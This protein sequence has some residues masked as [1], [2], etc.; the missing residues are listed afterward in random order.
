MRPSPILGSPE[1]GQVQGRAPGG[2]ERG[3]GG[4]SLTRPEQTRSK[5]LQ[6]RMGGGW[7]P[8]FLAP[9]SLQGPILDWEEEGEAG[10]IPSPGNPLNGR[11]RK[12]QGGGTRPLPS[13]Q[14][15]NQWQP[16][17]RGQSASKLLLLVT[18]AFS[19]LTGGG[20]GSWRALHLWTLC[21]GI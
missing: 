20:E 15:R 21:L 18:E 19:R 8:L 11:T 17:Y 9:D 13:L 4:S 5:L 16:E 10:D 7:S 12:G 1:G 2:V 14:G 3:T 6:R